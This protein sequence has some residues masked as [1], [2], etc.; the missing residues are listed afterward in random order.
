MG[1]ERGSVREGKQ[2]IIKNGRGRGRMREKENI[3][4]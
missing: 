2:K 3:N 1:E 4:K